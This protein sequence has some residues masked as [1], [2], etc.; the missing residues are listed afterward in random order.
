MRDR[1]SRQP[2][3]PRA[4][5]RLAPVETDRPAVPLNIPRPT[6]DYIIARA[7]EFDA[8]MDVAAEPVDDG[9]R[10][11]DLDR[12]LLPVQGDDTP[13]DDLHNAL[14]LLN[15]E[16]MV[17]LVAILWVGRGDYDRRDWKDARQAA[18]DILEERDGTDYLCGTPLIADYLT[19]G[20][21]ALGYALDDA[22]P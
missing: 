7:R 3:A 1:L 22:G 8:A 5:E 15:D 16:Q 2:P 21:D 4:N 17:T 18:A 12:D 19:E 20:L 9:T 11:L 6:L 13:Y 14:S 10:L